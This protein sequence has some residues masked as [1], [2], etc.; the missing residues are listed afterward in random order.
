M[1]AIVGVIANLNT[2]SM[3]SRTAVSGSSSRRSTDSSSRRSSGS[4][5]TAASRWDFARL[6]ATANTSRAR[7]RRRRS[8]SRPSA[9][10]PARCSSS[11]AS[12]SS[13]FSPR[14]ASVST[15]GGRRSLSASPTIERTSFSIVFAAG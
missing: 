8:S 3:I 10:S 1:S 7:F 9:A 4:S 12:S 13:T 5:A 14:I 6:D 11:A 15:I 2:F